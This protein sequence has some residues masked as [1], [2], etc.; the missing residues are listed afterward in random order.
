MVWERGNWDSFYLA[1]KSFLQSGVFAK[2]DAS[3]G[4]W[5]WKVMQSVSS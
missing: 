4:D 1:D 2:Q 5:L 3:W